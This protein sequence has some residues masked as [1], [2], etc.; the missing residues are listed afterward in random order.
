MNEWVV[1]TGSALVVLFMIAM[2]ALLGFRDRARV[3]EALI[4]KLAAEE[5]LQSEAALVAPDGRAG[6]ARLSGGKL[7][8]ARVMGADI[9][10]RVAPAS[11]T[12]VTWRAGKLSVAFAD[13]GYPPLHMR[14]DDAPPWV[15]A[16]ARGDAA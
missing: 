12:R 5:G 4:A 15:A 14:V 13:V 1:I 6:F 2:A 8:I 3:D 7:M 11:S 16:L 9:S 10:T